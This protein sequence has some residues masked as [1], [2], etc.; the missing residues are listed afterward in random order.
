MAKKKR[1]DRSTT[2]TPSEPFNNPFEALRALASEKS[3]EAEPHPS[4]QVPSE[5]A[6]DE[7][8]PSRGR[9]VVL[10]REKKGRGGKTVTCIEG[11]DAPEALAQTLARAMGC[12]ATIEAETL[13]L[14]GDQTQRAADWLRKQGYQRVVIGN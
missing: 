8:L 13:I 10:R 3:A 9:K 5:T 12:G 11:L 6:V 4:T 7:V 1:E 14:Q 2:Q